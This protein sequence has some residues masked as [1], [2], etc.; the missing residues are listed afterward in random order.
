[1]PVHPLRDPERELPELTRGERFVRAFDLY[2]GFCPGRSLD[3]ADALAIYTAVAARQQIF[4]DRCQSC[5]AV[6]IRD[7]NVNNRFRC[8]R[9]VDWEARPS[10]RAAG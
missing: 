10:A 8:T 6:I 4:A 5:Q 2:H 7:V 1:M 9:C 3:F